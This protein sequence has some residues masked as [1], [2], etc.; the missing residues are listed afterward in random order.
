MCSTVNPMFITPCCAM[1]YLDYDC[2]N[3]IGR[4]FCLE[5]QCLVAMAPLHILSYH[6]KQAQYVV[7]AYCTFS[8]SGEE[9][10]IDHPVSSFV[11]PCHSERQRRISRVG[12][13]DS[14]LTLRM[15]CSILILMLRHLVS[16]YLTLRLT[17]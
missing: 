11:H 3:M 5:T 12:H 6:I 4:N 16:A 9:I 1:E 8:S 7:P 2:F 13:R 15:T 17:A 10:R 14:S